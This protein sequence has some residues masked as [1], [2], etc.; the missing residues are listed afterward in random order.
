[1]TILTDKSTTVAVISSCFDLLALPFGND[2][3]I[4][5]LVFRDLETLLSTF[6]TITSA[7]FGVEKERRRRREVRF[8]IPTPAMLLSKWEETESSSADAISECLRLIT[9]T[10]GVV[11][12]LAVIV[13]GDA[14]YVDVPSES[15]SL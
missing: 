4:R 6:R 14:W 5:K 3:N 12:S 13:V 10:G 9:V 8:D 11:V 2:L 15:P 7:T 1:M